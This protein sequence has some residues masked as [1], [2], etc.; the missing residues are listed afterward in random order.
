MKPARKITVNGKP[1]K[2][3]IVSLTLIDNRSFEADSLTLVFS[4]PDNSINL[5]TKDSKI[6]CWIGWEIEGKTTLTHKGSFVAGHPSYDINPREITVTAKTVNFRKGLN[7]VRTRSYNDTT[8]GSI[9]GKIAKR[10][11]LSVKIP[12][13]HD[14]IVINHIDQKDESDGHFLT[15]LA[16]RYDALL[17]IKNDTLIWLPQGKGKTAGGKSLSTVYIDVSE[18]ETASYQGQEKDSEYTGVKAKWHNTDTGKTE[19]EIAGNKGKYQRLKKTYSNKSE[20][21]AAAQSEWNKIQRGKHTLNVSLT[22]G[23]PEWIT[24]SPVRV[25]GI[26]NEV[27][28]ITWSSV[29]VTHNQNEDGYTCSADLESSAD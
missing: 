17:N 24:E 10:Q 25:S 7:E 14:A 1:I 23:K 13:A 26:K 8:L 20:A 4:D 11:K 15:R 28:N 27:D 21:Q 16:Q 2:A 22:H 3:D 6:E 12:A 5:P 18:C 9:V 29:R 19:W